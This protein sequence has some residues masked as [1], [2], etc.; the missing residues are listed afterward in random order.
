MPQFGSVSSMVASSGT[1][2]STSSTNNSSWKAL[3]E[4]ALQTRHCQM[5]ISLVQRHKLVRVVS[6]SC[7]GGVQ[8]GHPDDGVLAATVRNAR[9][10]I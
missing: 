4:L 2:A 9:C 10:G 3:L 8:P 6:E 5:G 1:P 7:C